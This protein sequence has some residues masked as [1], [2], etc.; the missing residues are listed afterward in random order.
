M[1]QRILVIEDNP[2]ISRVVQYELEQAGYEALTAP[3]GISGLT[4]A[5][6]EHPDLV[7]LD[8]GLPDLDGAEVTRRLRKNSSMPIIILTAMDAL[9]RKVALLEAGADDYMT[10]PF[11]PE[12]L[13]ARVKVQ[14]RH[15]QHGDV[16]RV[17]DLEIHPQ[18]RLCYFKGHEVRL[19]PREF[20]LLTF[21]ARQPGRVY[22]RAEIE[23]EVW[24]G[25]LPSN[26]NVVD[27][28]M[29]NMR[30]KL[31][32]LDG[33]GLIRTVRGIGYALKTP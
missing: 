7:I 6:E 27:V 4:L 14:L 9:D 30:S 1:E 28:H 15:Q 24:S 10:K 23:R 33:Y 20:D 31:R 25:D 17:G 16:I 26:S 19:S 18:K 12:E 32:D 2:D 5:R 11:Y 8:L 13:V 29:A 21:L 22:S 3:D